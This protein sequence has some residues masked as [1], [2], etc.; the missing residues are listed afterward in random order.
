MEQTCIST[1]TPHSR[2]IETAGHET[3]FR[4]RNYQS[5]RNALVFF[6]DLSISRGFSHYFLYQTNVISTLNVSKLSTKMVHH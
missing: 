4:T 6:Y 5:L 2:A 3:N 1:L